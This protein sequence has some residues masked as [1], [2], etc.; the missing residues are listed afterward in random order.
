[1]MEASVVR[2]MTD[3]ATVR[4]AGEMPVGMELFAGYELL[5]ALRLRVR[6]RPCVLAHGCFTRER[7][8]A[9]KVLRGFMLRAAR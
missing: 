9:A 3:I 4:H 8:R 6:N 5:N 7:V 2:A 1:M